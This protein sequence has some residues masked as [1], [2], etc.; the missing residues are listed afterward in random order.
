MRFLFAFLLIAVLCSPTFAGR[1]PG[2]VCPVA[3]PAP[4][5][6]PCA[7][8]VCT[9]ACSPEVI[10]PEVCSPAGHT[11][12]V[13]RVLQRVRNSR[14]VILSRRVVGRLLPRNRG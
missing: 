1:C 11:R 12:V 3:P 4:V 14:V 6:T 9:P 8:E 7:P 13:G 5:V 10:A 2:G